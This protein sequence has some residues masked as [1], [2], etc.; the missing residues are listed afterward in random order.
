[1][2]ISKTQS[3]QTRPTTIDISFD[4]TLF[5]PFGVSVKKCVRGCNTIN[6]PY[7]LARG[8]NKVKNMNVKLS[9]LMSG[10]NETKFL[11]QNKLCW[12]KCGLN[13]SVC[14]SKQKWD[15]KWRCGFKELVACGSCKASCMSNPSTKNYDSNKGCKIDKY[16]DSKN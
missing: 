4:Q 15:Y 2:G 1:M 10:V 5:Y 12:C 16:L 3:Y 13:E 7:A 6:D 8:P 14:N 9:N 11:V